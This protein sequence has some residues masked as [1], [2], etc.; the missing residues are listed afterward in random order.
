MKV[1]ITYSD[2]SQ[3]VQLDDNSIVILSSPYSNGE[4]KILS[5]SGRDIGY[6]TSEYPNGHK[7]ANMADGS[8][9]DVS[10]KPR[11]FG[12]SQEEWQKYKQASL[13]EPLKN[14]ELCKENISNE[15][16][17]E[18]NETENEE[19][20]VDSNV[21]ITVSSDF[22]PLTTL[23]I[24]NDEEK[25]ISVLKEEINQLT[26]SYRYS[27]VQYDISSKNRDRYK[28]HSPGWEGC[29]NACYKHREQGDKYKKLKEE[30]AKQLIILLDQQKKNKDRFV[31]EEDRKRITFLGK[32]LLENLKCYYGNSSGDIENKFAEF[33]IIPLTKNNG[34]KA[35][36]EGKD[37]IRALESF[38]S[39]SGGYPKGWKYAE[40]LLQKMGI[41][42][43]ELV[44]AR[45]LIKDQ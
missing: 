2:G 9:Y 22:Y 10:E 36:K 5:E 20:L 32:E 35:F 18:K 23:N 11:W 28:W 30:K 40:F 12:G 31:S 8:K 38:F 13:N 26:R 42:T 45:L 17:E 6:L 7:Y 15:N 41:K 24:E 4:R 25:E 19:E 3:Q 33:G 16:Q 37:V 43:Q 27:C 29:N 44:K 34:E 39:M 14:E 1:L 21:E